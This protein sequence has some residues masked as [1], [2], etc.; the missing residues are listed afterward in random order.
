MAAKVVAPLPHPALGP[1]P[2]VR[3]F[4]GFGLRPPRVSEPET[5]EHLLG[6]LFCGASLVGG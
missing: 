2:G 5:K 6:S 4:P 1:S 3:P